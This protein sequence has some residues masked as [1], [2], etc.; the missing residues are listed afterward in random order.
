V[1][2]LC[3]VFAVRKM[4]QNYML[5]VLPNIDALST[6]IPTQEAAT[7]I[8]LQ[9]T[10]GTWQRVF[11]SSRDTPFSLYSLLTFA[12]SQQAKTGSRQ[13]STAL[14]LI[15]KSS[16]EAIP[17]VDDPHAQ[18]VAKLHHVIRHQVPKWTGKVWRG[19]LHSPMEILMMAIKGFLCFRPKFV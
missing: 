5:S 10:S 11:F 4:M 13:D 8:L 3:S 16:S 14:D 1:K 15:G 7:Q 18:L 17:R 12:H 9:Y 19:A 6:D 2:Y